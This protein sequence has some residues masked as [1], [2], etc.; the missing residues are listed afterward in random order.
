MYY[1]QKRD[2]PL[3]LGLM[4][5]HKIVFCI[6]Y[7]VFCKGIHGLW[8]DSHDVQL[9]NPTPFFVFCIL[10]R[11]PL[12]WGRFTSCAV[13]IPTS[14]VEIKTLPANLVP[15]HVDVG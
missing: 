5:I 1:R 10:H 12:A 11:F 6:L 2:Q 14:N 13:I 3:L 4:T 9:S 15:A 7:F 8:T